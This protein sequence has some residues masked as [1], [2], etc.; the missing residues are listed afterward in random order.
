MWVQLWGIP[1]DLM[2]KAV[3]MEIGNNMGTCIRVD[4][5]LWS[6]DQAHFMRIRVALMV[7]VPLR[8]GGMIVSPEGERTWVHYWYK[9]L[10]MFCFRCGVLGHDVCCDVLKCTQVQVSQVVIKS[11]G[12]GGMKEMG[13]PGFPFRF[14]ARPRGTGC[15]NFAASFPA[16]ENLK[17]HHHVVINASV[18]GDNNGSNGGDESNGKGEFSNLNSH[19]FNMEAEVRGKETLHENGCLIDTESDIRTDLEIGGGPSIPSPKPKKP[20]TWK[21]IHVD[22]MPYVT[23][24]LR[25]GKIGSKRS[26]RLNDVVQ[27]VIGSK[28]TKSDVEKHHIV[29]S[30]VKYEWRL[31]EFYGHPEHHKRSASWALLDH[32]RTRD[33]R[34]WRDGSCKCPSSARPCSSYGKLHGLL[35]QRRKRLHRFEDKWVLH[36]DCEEVVESTWKKEVTNG[37]PMFIL[38][39]KI[40]A[41]YM[42]LV[43][44]SARVYGGPKEVLLEKLQFLEN[45]KCANRDGHCEF[46]DSLAASGEK[47]NSSHEP[48]TLCSLLCFRGS[49]SSVSDASQQKSLALDVPKCLCPEEIDYRQCCSGFRAF[50]Q[51]Q[52]QNGTGK[53]GQMAVKLDMSKAYDRVEWTFLERL[54]AKLGFDGHWVAMV[55][56]CIKTVSYSIILNGE[57][58]GLI[59]PSK[60]DSPRGSYLFLFWGA[61]NTTHFE[62]Y[63]GL[64]TVVGQNKTQAFKGIRDSVVRRLEGWKEQMLSKAGR[65][66]G[67]GRPIDIWLD[68]WTPKVFAEGIEPNEVSKVVELVDQDCGWWNEALIDRTFDARKCCDCETCAASES[69][70]GAESSTSFS[71]TLPFGERCGNCRV[72]GK[73]HHMVW[74]ACTNSLP[75]WLNLAHRSVV[76]NPLYQVCHQA[77][78]DVT[79]A[80]WACP[81]MLK[82]YGLWPLQSSKK[83][84]PLPLISIL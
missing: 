39:E 36:L 68:R 57:P 84:Q 8:R 43:Q 5:R 64:P 11:R 3:G 75:T 76:L 62:K 41:V 44:W 2:S 27:P 7:E 10:P 81:Y 12:N 17:G 26:F 34:P 72:P 48:A 24:T 54:M 50:A 56:A 14:S 28:R 4:D 82:T 25:N 9:R 58:H 29:E 53:K 33:I 74:R 65:E 31:T 45:L 67:N 73:V 78:K 71:P 20:T 46:E 60:G 32:W 80:L 49:P 22:H 15:D 38:C 42:A 1:F 19:G 69:I 77:Q 51:I 61:S 30:E 70:L 83:Q 37:S 13:T 55:M 16:R 40:K 47:D 63:L 66:V 52:V 35:T 59:H 18:I 23:Y 6:T 79:H 21:R